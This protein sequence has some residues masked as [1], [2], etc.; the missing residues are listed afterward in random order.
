MISEIEHLDLV[1]FVWFLSE[2]TFHE[3]YKGQVRYSHWFSDPAPTEGRQVKNFRH[4]T[5]HVSVALPPIIL[6]G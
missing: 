2:K 3:G 4:V 5:A 1:F 6:T